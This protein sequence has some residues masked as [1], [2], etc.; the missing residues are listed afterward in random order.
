MVGTD[1]LT[2]IGDA[3]YEAIEAAVMETARGRWFLAQFA[4]RN[5]NADTEVILGAIDRLEGVVVSERGA[6]DPDRLR[7]DLMEMAKAIARTKTEIAAMHPADHDQSR[8]VAATEALDGI[9]RTTEQA[10]SDILEAAEYVQEAAWTLREAGANPKHCDE[11]DRRATEIY[12][13]CSFQD[14]TAQRTAKIVETLRYLEARI[15]AMIE[16]WDARDEIAPEGDPLPA[17]IVPLVSPAE[18]SQQ[19]VDRVIVNDLPPTQPPRE[20]TK[21]RPE[22]GAEQ[23]AVPAPLPFDGAEVGRDHDEAWAMADLSLAHEEPAVS[24]VDDESGADRLVETGELRPEAFAEIDAL[25]M[26]EKLR[27]FT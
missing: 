23:Q 11:L 24:D 5:R 13:A 21:H 6:Q 12:T 22:Q 7:F 17:N 9:V 10:T 2:T 4:R 27:R 3:E 18:L 25:D 26:R 19:E 1:S 20:E 14:L 15:N 8:L 16:I